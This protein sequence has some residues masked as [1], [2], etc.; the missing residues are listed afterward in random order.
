MK[1]GNRILIVLIICMLAFYHPMS[2][3][4]TDISD[5]DMDIKAFENVIP[6][7]DS[8]KNTEAYSDSNDLI[9]EVEDKAIIDFSEEA[10]LAGTDSESFVENQVAIEDIPEENGQIDAPKDTIEDL[11]EEG[12]SGDEYPEE[13]YDGHMEMAESDSY[14]SFLGLNATNSNSGTCGDNLTWSLSDSG[15]LTISGTG[16]MTNYTISGGANV[17]PWFN[18][19]KIPRIKSV[20]ISDGVT[21]IGDWAF[22]C[23]SSLK[24]VTIPSSVQSIGSSAFYYCTQLS[25]ISLPSGIREIK[26]G[27][28]EGCSNLKNITLPSTITK[29]DDF[30]F[31]YVKFSSII[32]PSNVKE[33]GYGVFDGCSNLTTIRIPD[34]VSYLPES[35]FV[36]C[37]SLKSAYIPLSVK[38]IDNWAFNGCDN[39]T[40]IYYSGSMQEWKWITFGTYQGS[41]TSAGLTVHCSNGD[42]RGTE[43]D[44]SIS[45]NKSSVSIP[46]GTVEILTATITGG[47][48][49]ITWTSSNNNIASVTNKGVVTAVNEGKA[50]ITA[51]IKSGESATCQVTVTKFIPNRQTTINKASVSVKSCTYNGQ[52]QEPSVSVKLKGKTLVKD[53]DYTVSYA[54]NVNV[55]KSATVNVAGIGNY[56]GVI[57]KKFEIK[58][59]SI[60]N[61]NVK[62]DID[63]TILV[64]DKTKKT[65][66]CKVKL[67][68]DNYSQELKEGSDYT[69][70][71]QN[72]KKAGKASL[73]LKGKG[74]FKDSRTIKFAIQKPTIKIAECFYDGLPQEPEITSIVINN[75]TL[76]KSDYDVEY[77]NNVN[78]SSKAVCKII[79]KGDYSGTVIQN[80]KISPQP[81]SLGNYT[82]IF[83]NTYTYNGKNQKPLPDNVIFDNGVAN[84][85]LKY[86]TDYKLVQKSP[87][88]DCKNVGVATV[89][90][91]LLGNYSGVLEGH[92]NIVKAEQHLTEFPEKISF[93]ENELKKKKSKTIS[94]KG[95]L[96]N[97][98]ITF[99]PDDP[100][101]VSVNKN[102]KITPKKSGRTTISIFME[103]TDNTYSY[104]GIFPVIVEGK[105]REKTPI[106][107]VQTKQERYVA[108]G[109]FNIGATSNGFSIEYSI[110]NDNDK[111]YAT[112]DSTGKVT[113]IQ[114]DKW[115]ATDGN[116]KEITIHLDCGNISKD[117]SL[118]LKVDYNVNQAIKY[119]LQMYSSSTEWCA[120]F[121]SKCL[122]EGGIKV[123]Q[124]GV[125]ELR[126][127]LQNH[128]FVLQKESIKYEY[129]YIYA[130][131]KNA[132]RISV[133]DVLIYQGLKDDPSPAHAVIVTEIINNKVYVAGTHDR[134]GGSLGDHGDYAGGYGT[135]DK[136][137]DK[138]PDH[139]CKRGET[140][141]GGI[142][143]YCLHYTGK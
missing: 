100:S 85:S 104:S 46:V 81:A 48:E 25:S 92:Y 103:E 88:K 3:L 118:T 130:T 108:D 62:V 36:D 70:S 77:S 105:E 69:V 74:N 13:Y 73:I 106:I 52:A 114:W 54:N 142:W 42:I 119:A 82:V 143:I 56:S 53:V 31:R 136:N 117:V 87:Y 38:R 110:P 84:Y 30:A 41:L 22:Q 6:D 128:G 140:D 50:T 131:G 28:F 124:K 2:V 132:G 21:V 97:P 33:I 66:D 20:V 107:E 126:S 58:K 72:N 141:N 86:K 75:K 129:P 44:K 16:E 5:K 29:I 9:E 23:L 99:T 24:N 14:V 49:E 133:G 109:E 39:L 101:I 27:T 17:S 115:P 111:K 83:N 35:L 123:Y 135:E 34:G 116:S 19:E 137:G 67:E 78:A 93:S 64:Y 79:F 10:V 68:Y 76:A 112:I 63:S 59:L 122:Q 121:V 45:L 138:E 7:D 55:G 8:S 127:K 102:G 26:K 96:G 12:L 18:Q 57:N 90:L 65:P 1:V 120:G 43:L 15:V 139:W 71:Y 32:I 51:S 11:S 61:T 37:S 47:D 95:K 80:F 113:P 4:A 134:Q 98:Q 89:K 60:K 125:S 91:Q 94:T 40:D